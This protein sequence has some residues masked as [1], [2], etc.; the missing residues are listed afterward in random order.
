MAEVQSKKAVS[1]EKPQAVM[2]A[3]Q[4]TQWARLAT[5]ANNLA[6]AST[7][8]FKSHIMKI[9]EVKQKSRDGK[10]I[11]FVK[12]AGVVRDSSSGG[13]NRTGNPLDVALIGPGYLMI[14]TPNGTTRYT[15][16]GQ[17]IVNTEGQLVMASTQYPVMGE[18][19]SEISIPVGAGKVSISQDGVVSANGQ[20]LGKL[21]VVA[22]DHD[23]AVFN[24]GLNLYKT[25]EEAK[26]ATGFS[27]IQGALEESNVSPMVES[28]NLME[29][30]RAFE[31]AQKII[32]EYDQLQRKAINASPRN[33]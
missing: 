7:H 23:E 13:I 21:A 1:I 27:L 16:N 20:I 26:P 18:S 2:L 29:I 17:F 22:F 33:V 3:M 12:T 25:E 32:D 5:A 10:M 15:R 4:E 9:E 30:L 31:S 24:E 14:K 8:G 11:S 28:I 6:N 19:G